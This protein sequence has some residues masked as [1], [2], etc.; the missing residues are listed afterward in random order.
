MYNKSFNLKPG[1][2]GYDG[3]KGDSTMGDKGPQGLLIWNTHLQIILNIIVPYLITGVMGKE[4]LCEMC[5]G[6]YFFFK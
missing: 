1:D 2:T 5:E 6:N 3:D 4:S